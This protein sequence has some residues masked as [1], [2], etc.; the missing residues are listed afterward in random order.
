MRNLNSTK[1]ININ[2]KSR[3]SVLMLTALLGWLTVTMIVVMISIMLLYAG[4]TTTRSSADR[5]A[6]EMAERLNRGNRVGEINE[7]VSYSRQLVFSS[8]GIDDAV[9]ESYPQMKNLS[10]YLLDDAR[11]GAVLVSDETAVLKTLAVRDVT[12]LADKKR[13]AAP[14]LLDLPMVLVAKP[15]TASILLGSVKSIPSNVRLMNGLA[16]LVEYDTARCYCEKSGKFY[17]SNIDARLPFPDS[18][19]CFP[20]SCTQPAA[21]QAVANL[22]LIQTADFEPMATMRKEHDFRA[23]GV[24]NF[25]PCAL[26]LNQGVIVR[27]GS[28]EL[29]H[30]SSVGQ[31]AAACATGA[32]PQEKD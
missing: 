13:G 19:L 2:R 21:G 14:K 24:M 26:Q 27:L 1:V 30:T 29:C 10:Q 6:L 23:E 8:R 25:I 5:K 28:P 20:F 12:A 22:R 17:R 31:G 3:G 11:K 16:K 7:M 15:S 4:L 9:K 32:C 18:D